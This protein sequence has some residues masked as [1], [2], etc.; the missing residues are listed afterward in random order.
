MDEAEKRFSAVLPCFCWRSTRGYDSDHHETCPAYYRPV[1]AQALREEHEWYLEFKQSY[2]RE[3]AQL[4]A[5]IDKLKADLKDWQ[6]N[7]FGW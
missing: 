3:I 6:D 2:E 5:E 4:K 7:S 1:V